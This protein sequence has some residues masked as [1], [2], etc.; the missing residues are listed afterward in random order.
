MPSKLE[1]VSS[2]ALTVKKR[3]EREQVREQD[4]VD[5]ERDDAPPC[6]A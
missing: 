6:P 1:P 4:E 3:A 2:A 5:R